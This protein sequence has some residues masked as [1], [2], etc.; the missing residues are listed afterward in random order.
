MIDHL[1]HVEH[2]SSTAVT[3]VALFPLEAWQQ[4]FCAGPG[5]RRFA[6]ATQIRANLVA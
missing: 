5:G 1:A 4:K 3:I 2:E 6:A